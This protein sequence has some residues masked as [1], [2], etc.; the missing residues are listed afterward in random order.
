MMT[1]GRQR[2][3]EAAARWG[4]AAVAF[5]W[6]SWRSAKKTWR[7]HRGGVVLTPGG[8]AL[9]LLGGAVDSLGFLLSLALPGFQSLLRVHCE[10][11][12]KG[13]LG[14]L[15]SGLDFYRR[16]DGRH[17]SSL[18]A[19]AD[20]RLMASP[21]PRARLRAHRTS[22][23]VTYGAQPDDAG[24]WLYDNAPESAGFGTLR[25]NCTHTDYRRAAWNSY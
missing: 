5:A 10:G 7:L 19:L 23:F 20:P 1:C 16:Q 2:A 8:D 3:D 25:I 22:P 15:R 12:A 13:N 4:V 21:L 18:E 14:A 11:A 9:V 17:P 6:L 24:G